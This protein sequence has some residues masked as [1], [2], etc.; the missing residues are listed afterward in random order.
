M[1]DILIAIGAGLIVVSVIITS[2]INKKKGK[3]SCG[4]DCSSCAHCSHC[5]SM[6]TEK[7]Q[8]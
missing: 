5:K 6:D 8:K 2:I 3:S 4:C 7:T 1:I